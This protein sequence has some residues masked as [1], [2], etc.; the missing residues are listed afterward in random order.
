M[1]GAHHRLITELGAAQAQ[2]RPG[3][4][5]TVDRT[6]ARQ[7]IHGAV[8][9]CGLSMVRLTWTDP[10]PSGPSTEEREAKR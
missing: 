10:P 1:T 4:R 6:P 2:R 9:A 5:I 7:E 8:V 3:M